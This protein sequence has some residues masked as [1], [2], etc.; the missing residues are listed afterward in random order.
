[1]LNNLLLYR[2]MLFNILCAVALGWAWQLGWVGDMFLK[3][4]SYM[5]YAALALFA[6]GLVSTFSRAFK[7]G[8]LLNTLKRRRH[9]SINGNKLVEKAAHLDD[10]GSLIV[11]AGLVGT[12]IGVVM[13]LHSF[14]AGSLTDPAKVVQTASMLGDG[15]GTAFRSTIVSSIFWMVHICNVRMLKTATV[16]LIED[17]KGIPAYE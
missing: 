15:V 2:L 9:I 11:T 10:I 6:V 8:G 1:M 12:A 13:M 17:E 14:D 16:M 3:D 4:A 7:I 5:T